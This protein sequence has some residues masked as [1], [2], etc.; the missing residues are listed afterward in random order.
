MILAPTELSHVFPSV[1]SKCQCVLMRVA[2]G[3]G[4]RSVSAF[5]NC[6]RDTPIPASTSTL[7]SGPVRTAMFP[8][9][10][11]SA[12]IVLR[13]LCTAIGE[14]AAL[15]LIRLTRPRASAK[16]WRGLSPP[17]AAKPPE[18]RQQRQKARLEKPEDC[19]AFILSS[20]R[21][22]TDASALQGKEWHAPLLS[23]DS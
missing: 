19:V 12:L 10:P 18:A 17:V 8:P 6:G 1:W 21:A 14:V 4:L 3:S 22:K 13:S 16:A 23:R 5:I 11:S 15:S 20:I 7:P 2:T 9:E